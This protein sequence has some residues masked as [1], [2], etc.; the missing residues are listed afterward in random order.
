[1]KESFP[2][3]TQRYGITVWGTDYRIVPEHIYSQ[4]ADVTTYKDEQPV[5]AGPYTVEDY[6]SN[7]DWILYKLRDD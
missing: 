2:R 6:D 4:Q 3:F 5:V 1:M 7:G